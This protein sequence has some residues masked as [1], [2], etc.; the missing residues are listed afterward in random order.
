MSLKFLSKKITLNPQTLL[1][2]GYIILLSTY[3][4]IR[5]FSVSVVHDEAITYFIAQHNLKDIFTFSS[6]GAFAVNNHLLNTFLIKLFFQ[7][8]GDFQFL[9]RLPALLG[10]FL[11]LIFSVK[12]SK[13]L[14][15]KQWVIWALLGLTLNPFLLDFFSLARGYSLAL[16]LILTSIYFFFKSLEKK[17]TTRNFLYLIVFGILAS[18]ANFSFLTP[19]LAIFFLKICLQ[20]YEVIKLKKLRTIRSIISSIIVPLFAVPGLLYALIGPQ[21]L[22]LKKT[23]QL[24]VGGNKG[25]F[26][27]TIMSLLNGFLYGKSYASSIKNILL[28]L[29]ILALIVGALL[30]IQAY[31]TKKIDQARNLIYLGLI[32]LI[33]YSFTQLQHNIFGTVFVT[34]RAALYFIPIFILFLLLTFSHLY[35]IFTGK[36]KKIL[37]VS[38]IAIVFALVSHFLLSAN[39]HST[40][41]WKYD[42]DTKDI[43]ANINI[44][45][46]ASPETKL[47][48]WNNWHLE[49]SINYYKVAENLTWL[50]WSYRVPATEAY[51]VYILFPEDY[52]LLNAY[53][54][55]LIKQY[56]TSGVV[57]AVRVAAT[58]SAT[59]NSTQ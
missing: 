4:V 39:F 17:S 53:P 27:D 13:L 43:L 50:N 18:I 28:V 59:T 52:Y 16:G 26:Q 10:F 23:G 3:V 20:I 7:L 30:C 12:V 49:P 57:L 48:V 5:V 38:G 22:L 25:F 24:Y 33:I 41:I 2:A 36:A 55:R 47:I 29:L 14:L 51:N 15:P 21:L 40:N 56:E 44:I 35:T 37:A 54:L 31:R 58:P 1:L 46:Q 8:F 45:H 11:Y 6:L 19:F 34:D 32:L 9:L 42:A